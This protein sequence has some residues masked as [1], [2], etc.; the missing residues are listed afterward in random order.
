MTPKTRD[1]LPIAHK[2][3]VIVP[4]YAYPIL[5]MDVRWDIIR[6]SWLCL[7]GWKNVSEQKTAASLIENG[8]DKRRAENPEMTKNKLM[9]NC[10]F[11]AITPLLSPDAYSSTQVFEAVGLT[12]TFGPTYLFFSKTLQY[13]W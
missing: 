13:T 7:V 9:S 10:L 3:D 2:N 12:Y 4:V 6:G 5:I 1:G 8:Y 11:G